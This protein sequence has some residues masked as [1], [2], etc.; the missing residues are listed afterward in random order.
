M[1]E[2]MI[3]HQMQPCPVSCVTTCMAMII[4]MPVSDMRAMHEEYVGGD[5]GIG[6]ILRRLG[7]PFTDFR[8][9][10]RYSL[11]DEGVFLVSVPSLNIQGGM[12]QV[13]VEMLSDADWRVYDPNQ[14]KEG[15]LYYT[16]LLGLDDPAAIMLG[17]GYNIDAA[18]SR[19]D[20]R[21][22]RRSR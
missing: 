21:E 14:G 11:G 22:W 3:E 16:S 18:I 6:E 8:S 15:K 19:G 4:G 1:S 2:F 5:L 20:L 12:H 10:E 9:S 7:I 17:G 13:V